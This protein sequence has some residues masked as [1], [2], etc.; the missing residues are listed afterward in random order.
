MADG[1]RIDTDWEVL[2]SPLKNSIVFQTSIPKL[3]DQGELT[4]QVIEGRSLE[5]GEYFLFDRLIYSFNILL[6]LII[7]IP[8]HLFFT[9]HLIKSDLTN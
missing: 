9:K 3:T 1:C 4:V 7:Y 6:P 5:A 2:T 8:Y